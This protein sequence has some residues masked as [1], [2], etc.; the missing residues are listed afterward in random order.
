MYNMGFF[1]TTAA[2]GFHSDLD[3]YA[4]TSDKAGY[5]MIPMHAVAVRSRDWILNCQMACL[6]LTVPSSAV[7][8]L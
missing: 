8:L 3:Y 4:L 7:R 1:P 6:L 5:Y 2:A